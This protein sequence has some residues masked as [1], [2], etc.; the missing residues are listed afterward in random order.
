M[1]FR[2]FRYVWLCILFEFDICSLQLHDENVLD[3]K[4]GKGN[5]KK[6]LTSN[7]LQQKQKMLGLLICSSDNIILKFGR[8]RPARNA[9]IIR[10]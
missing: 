8:N 1:G 6:G 3:L 2:C 4:A 10:F 5:L 7:K 9:L